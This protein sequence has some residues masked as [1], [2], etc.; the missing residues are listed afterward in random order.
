[1]VFMQLAIP[2]VP[3]PCPPPLDGKFLR[4]GTLEL[5]VVGTKKEGE[6]PVLNNTAAVLS[7]QTVD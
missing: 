2:A 4:V 1:M 7:D 5:P 6:S 3:I